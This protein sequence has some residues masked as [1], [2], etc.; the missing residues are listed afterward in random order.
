MCY[1]LNV[2][3]FERKL[4]VYLNTACWFGGYQSVCASSGAPL[5]LLLI[6]L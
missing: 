4:D 5:H 6:S 2:K 3:N 1:Q